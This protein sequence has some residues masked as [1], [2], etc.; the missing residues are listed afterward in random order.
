MAV[1]GNLRKHA[2]PEQFQAHPLRFGFI[3]VDS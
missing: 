1:S 3:Q 2:S